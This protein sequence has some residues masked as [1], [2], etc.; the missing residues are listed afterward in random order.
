MVRISFQQ[1]TLLTEDGKK[2][3]WKK[4]LIDSEAVGKFGVAAFI[5]DRTSGKQAQVW[6]H[7]KRL[8]EREREKA[9]RKVRLQAIKTG[10][11]T[12]AAT[13]QLSE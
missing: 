5:K 10:C 12:R 2:L 13:L 6:I 11:Q 3:D 1:L 9:R 7:G 4:L 8:G